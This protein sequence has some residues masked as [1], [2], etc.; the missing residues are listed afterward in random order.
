F[1][2]L[3]TQFIGDMSA[4]DAISYLMQH[5]QSHFTFWYNNIFLFNNKATSNATRTELISRTLRD[6]KGVVQFDGK[7]LWHILA[8]NSIEG[9]E[10]FAQM[11]HAQQTAGFSPFIDYFDFDY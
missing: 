3:N 6:G 2:R 5:K 11:M 7:S 10:L 1:I 8:E 4:F 9:S